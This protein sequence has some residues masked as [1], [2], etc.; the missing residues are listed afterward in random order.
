MGSLKDVILRN[1]LIIGVVVVIIV[2]LVFPQLGLALGH[3]RLVSLKLTEVAI[4]WMFVASGVCLESAADAFHWKPLTLGLALILGA[5]PLLAWPILLLGGLDLNQDLLTGMALFCI[6]PTT[7]SSGVTMI[8]Q[9]NGNVSLAILMTA[10]SNILGVFLMPFTA[11]HVFAA[12]V[13]L[14]PWGLL[15]E[16]LWLTLAPLVVGMVLRKLVPPLASFA[17]KNKKLIGI[18]QNSCVVLVVLLMISK[19]QA[20]IIGAKTWDLVCC[21]FLAAGVH[22]VYRIVGY[23]VATAAQ[24]PPEDWVTVVLMCSQK[25]LPVCASVILGLPHAL[26]AKGGVFILPCILAHAAQLV[27][28]SILAVRW[29]VKAD[30]AATEKPL[31]TCE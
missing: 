7:L 5:T 28:D 12:N 29:E 25:S 31:L 15:R 4:C 24:L 9:A 26:Q 3:V 16:L 2:G 13:Q 22:L 10:L 23:V 17:K 18:S 20:H 14:E 21:V 8:T 6:V 11:S 27:I 19:A 1:F 30:I